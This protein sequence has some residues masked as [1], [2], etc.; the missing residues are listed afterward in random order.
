MIVM[1]TD[2]TIEKCM[3]LLFNITKSLYRYSYQE[4]VTLPTQ[5]I[6]EN[7]KTKPTNI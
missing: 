1:A 4:E 2:T 7:L 6:S 3:Q 5:I